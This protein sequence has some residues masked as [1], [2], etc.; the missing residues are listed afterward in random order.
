MSGKKSQRNLTGDAK[1]E[2]M[3]PSGPPLMHLSVMYLSSNLLLCKILMEI[4]LLKVSFLSKLR[5][6]A[7]LFLVI[8]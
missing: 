2:N 5:R 6:G 7:N 1:N 3:G 4:L 8:A